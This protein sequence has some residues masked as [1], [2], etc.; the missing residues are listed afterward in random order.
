ML[1]E[2][3]VPEPPP[4]VEVSDQGGVG[5]GDPHVALGKRH[6]HEGYER[7][8]EW[9][10]SV[11]F[12]EKSQIL[13]AIGSSRERRPGSVPGR[14]QETVLGPG[15][16]PGYCPQALY[17]AGFQPLRGPAPHI[18]E[19]QLPDRRSLV[20]EVQ[21]TLVLIDQASVG[22][23]GSGRY[24]FH[25]VYPGL[26]D[27]QVI[28]ASADFQHRRYHRV[29]VAKRQLTHAVLEGDHLSLLGY[30]D[31]A[32]HRTGWLRQYSVVARAS[33]PPDCAAPPVEEA[34][35]DAVFSGDGAEAA[36]NLI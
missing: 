9:P 7:F 28:I 27:F 14:E 16:Y 33:A 4:E 32:L 31:P 1:L 17:F 11:H 21:E 30:P 19:G 25:G 34:Q 36:L 35:P 13:R 20:K 29:Q 12:S 6:L 15:K 3:A 10:L 2:D 8:E 18:E 23:T 24:I 5:L 26:G 22:V